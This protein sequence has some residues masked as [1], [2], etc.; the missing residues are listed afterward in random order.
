MKSRFIKPLDEK[1]VA[2]ILDK[3]KEER[4]NTEKRE[5]EEEEEKKQNALKKKNL[6]YSKK[7][8]I[9]EKKSSYEDTYAVEKIN[10][11]TDFNIDNGNTELKKIELVFIQVVV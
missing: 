1:G 2:S 5:K 9:L 6:K 10:S 7:A 4:E 3:I 8:N 11:K